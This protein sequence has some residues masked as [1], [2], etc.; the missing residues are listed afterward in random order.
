M[1]SL[2]VVPVVVQVRE[3][4]AGGHYYSLR[5]LSE[6]TRTP[7]PDLAPVL[8]EMQR[9][10]MVTAGKPAYGTRTIYYKIREPK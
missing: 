5:D 1:R 9:A 4:L 6:L 2:S 10:G 3:A 7:M 8:R